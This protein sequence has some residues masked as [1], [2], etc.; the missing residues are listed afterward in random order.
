MQFIIDSNDLTDEDIE[1]LHK[2]LFKKNLHK[3]MDGGETVSAEPAS[4]I[5]SKDDNWAHPPYFPDGDYQRGYKDG[6][7]RGYE[8]ARYN[9]NQFQPTSP[10]NPGTTPWYAPGYPWTVTCSVSRS[11]NR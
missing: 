6:Y 7:S 9:G 4:S 1:L 10:R 11:S 2:I 3:T 8:D 5:G